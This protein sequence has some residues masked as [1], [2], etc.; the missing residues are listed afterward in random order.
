MGAIIKCPC[1]IIN[2]WRRDREEAG[3]YTS[4]PLTEH[5]QANINKVFPASILYE[6]SGTPG[7]IWK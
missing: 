3:Y 5:T 2:F 1:A 7:K 6:I 4:L